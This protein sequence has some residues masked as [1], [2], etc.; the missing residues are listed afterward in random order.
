MGW[1]STLDRWEAFMRRGHTTINYNL[2]QNLL[3]CHKQGFIVDMAMQT[4]ALLHSPDPYHCGNRQLSGSSRGLIN[5]RTGARGDTFFFFF[6]QNWGI[7]FSNYFMWWVRYIWNIHSYLWIFT[8]I[9]SVITWNSAFQVMFW[10]RISFNKVEVSSNFKK[11]FTESNTG[12]V[13][14][15]MCRQIWD[16]SDIRTLIIIPADF[17]NSSQQEIF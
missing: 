2:S 4:W 12:T 16:Y 1:S 8:H 9:Y 7:Q 6:Y 10:S 11:C 17:K 3:L 15:G 14:M 5:R 13:T